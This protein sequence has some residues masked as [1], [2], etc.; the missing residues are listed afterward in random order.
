MFEA[1]RVAVLDKVELAA[2]RM[3]ADIE[4]D[5]WC[6]TKAHGCNA[7]S[8]M[9]KLTDTLADLGRPGPAERLR[10]ARRAAPGGEAM[11]PCAFT[12]P[13][14]HFPLTESGLKAAFE[15]GNAA[16]RR[17]AMADVAA[18][19]RRIGA[20]LSAPGLASLRTQHAVGRID[21]AERIAEW[22]EERAKT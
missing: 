14:E 3:L 21:E 13:W 1:G 12:Q 10:A 11:S 7:C 20:T 15:A 19:A 16:G 4:H 8:G 5:S 9:D 18:E 6:Y 2:F 22:A 17:A